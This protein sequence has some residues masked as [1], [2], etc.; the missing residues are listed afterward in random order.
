MQGPQR[1]KKKKGRKLGFVLFLFF[2]FCFG[3]GQS[4]HPPCVRFNSGF[5]KA[6]DDDRMPSRVRTSG[7]RSEMKILI[8][9]C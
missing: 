2:F 1:R 8:R 6:V 7:T 3:F 5:T 4:N 9:K